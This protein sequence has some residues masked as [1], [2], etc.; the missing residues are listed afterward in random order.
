M[1]NLKSHLFETNAVKVCHGDKPF[2]YT[3]GKIGPYFINTHFV[4]GSEQDAAEFLNF[5]DENKDDKLNLPKKLFEKVL[6][7]YEENAIYH[8]VV[9]E[10]IEFIKANIHVDEIDY[11]SGGERRD[12]YFSVIAAHL[13]GKPHITIFKDLGAVTSDS[14]FE[15][16]KPATS[17]NGKKVLHI[18]DL[19][20]QASSYIRA[21]IPAIQDLGGELVWSLVLVDRMQGGKERL[22]DLGIRSFSIAQI[23]EDL[24][25]VA[26]EKGIIDEA[27]FELVRE[28]IK[29]PDGSM[30]KFVKEHPEFI[31]DALHSDAKT[32]GRAQLCIDSHFYGL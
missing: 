21:W 13:L 7:Q 32:A 17:L 24:F 10:M 27:Q 8:D 31:E 2:W 14:N 22:E 9:E 18:A 23:D 25:K 29:D 16:T 1:N 6:K 26:F 12:W 3:S 5:I 4:Y 28:F 15:D 20:N 11:I 30:E 19:M